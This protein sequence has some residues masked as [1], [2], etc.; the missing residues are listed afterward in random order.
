M[1]EER[2][3]GRARGRLDPGDGQFNWRAGYL[4]CIGAAVGYS[5]AA[6]LEVVVG[7]M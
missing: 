3:E 1:R 6:W 7:R 5:G 4:L 2:S